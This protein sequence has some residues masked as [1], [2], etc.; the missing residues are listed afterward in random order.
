MGAHGG[1]HSRADGDRIKMGFF[2]RKAEETGSALYRFFVW[3]FIRT[4]KELATKSIMK[5]NSYII[6]TELEGRNY[7]GKDAFLKN[8][9]LGYASYVQ[10]GC[11]LTDTDIGR[12]TS[13]GSGVKTVIGSHPVENKAALHPAFSTKE[14][15]TG[16]S[17]VKEN[18]Y[19][20]KQG[21][22]TVIGPDVW[23]GNDV[24]IMG[25]VKIGAG[26]VVGAGAIVTRDVPA[27][28]IN[29]GVPAKTIKY[30]FSEEQIEKLLDG[31][32]WEKDE[33]WIKAHINDFE[34]VERFL[35]V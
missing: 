31:K 5:Q 4:Y 15:I 13:I 9:S 18:I 23:L 28:S 33:Q 12:Y 27:Y 19:E 8:C 30:R 10:S 17:Y 14:N 22:R 7:I 2:K 16:L 3:P 21:V 29:V 1:D 32:W 26:A 34:D 24:R 6:K 35:N 20:G 11:D 25:G